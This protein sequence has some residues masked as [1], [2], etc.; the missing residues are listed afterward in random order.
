MGVLFKYFK[1]EWRKTANLITE[2][3]LIL[4]PLPGILL[5]V[6]PHD[7]V[8][9]WVAFLVF[10]G[11]VS[12][13]AL[14]GYVARKMNEVTDLGKLLDPL[15]DKIVIV[16]TLIA[17]CIKVDA[18][19]WLPAVLV[20]AREIA[21]TNLRTKASQ[22]GIVVPAI[23]IGKVKMVIQSIAIAVMIVPIT[24]LPWRILSLVMTFVMVVITIM[25]W[26]KY[27]RNFG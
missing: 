24:F 10:V 22:K 1:H 25:S 6:N 19:M 3:R 4:S 13:D 17:I 26:V 12:T 16:L 14:D 15:A 9:R 18:Y 7:E 23:R 2:T 27:N 20:I 5:F 8:L 11:I 21:I